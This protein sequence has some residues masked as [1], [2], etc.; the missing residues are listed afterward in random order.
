MWS[1]VNEFILPSSSQLVEAQ[2]RFL[3]VLMGNKTE[4]RWQK[5]IHHMQSV[6]KMPLGLLFIDKAF[7]EDSK[8]AVCGATF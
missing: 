4:L 3:Q 2:N 5:C 8:K 7:N 1:V 6:L